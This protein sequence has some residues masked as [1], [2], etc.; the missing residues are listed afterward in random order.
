MVWS[1]RALMPSCKEILR[2]GQMQASLLSTG[3]ILQA[4]SAG[5]CVGTSPLANWFACLHCHGPGATG[6]GAGPWNTAPGTDGRTRCGAMANV[7]AMDRPTN[8]AVCL[9]VT[10]GGVGRMGIARWGD[11]CVLWKGREDRPAVMAELIPRPGVHV[12]SSGASGSRILWNDLKKG[13]VGGAYL[14][15]ASA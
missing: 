3:S 4:L 9:L 12:M 14:V 7:A 1:T 2:C 10:M 11:A 5:G 6:A 8:A 13:S 15:H